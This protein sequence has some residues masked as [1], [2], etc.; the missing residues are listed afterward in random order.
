LPKISTHKIDEA[1]ENTFS[2]AEQSGVCQDIPPAILFRVA[3]DSALLSA[4]RR[5]M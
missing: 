2:D 5:E 1:L 3:R 4:S